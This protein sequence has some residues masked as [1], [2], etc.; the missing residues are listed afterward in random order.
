[1]ILSGEP[2][3]LKIISRFKSMTIIF[4]IGLSFST[5]SSTF[6]PLP[7]NT[8]KNV[9]FQDNFKSQHLGIIY[10]VLASRGKLS[11]FLARLCKRSRQ[12]SP[13]LPWLSALCPLPSLIWPVE[14]WRRDSSR[15]PSQRPDR[16]ARSRLGIFLIEATQLPVT[17]LILLIMF[18]SLAIQQIIRA[19]SRNKTN[20]D[21]EASQNSYSVFIA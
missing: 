8:T 12:A 7:R 20:A 13:T 14:G 16:T 3:L 10:I 4:K 6:H 1:M 5:P 19:M 11:Y 18:C 17:G 2:I 21:G 15:L 9:Q